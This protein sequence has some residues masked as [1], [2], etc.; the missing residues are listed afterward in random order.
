MLAYDFT[1]FKLPQHVIQNSKHAKAAQ[2]LHWFIDFTKW[3]EVNLMAAS[4]A[5]ITVSN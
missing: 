2:L 1:A 5:Y 4:V 3:I